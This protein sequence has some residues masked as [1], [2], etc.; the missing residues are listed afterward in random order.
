M[1]KLIIGIDHNPQIFDNL[2]LLPP[3][4]NLVIN[5]IP[6]EVYI[7]HR[8]ETSF[9]T[10]GIISN[11][12][13]LITSNI[14]SNHPNIF[15]IV[16]HNKLEQ[17]LIINRAYEHYKWKNFIPLGFHYS[18]GSK[19]KKYHNGICDN[20][21]SS[22]SKYA[23]FKKFLSSNGDNQA[24][25]PIHLLSKFN[26]SIK[27]MTNKELKKDYA[28]S[29]IF[30]DLDYGDD[31]H[32]IYNN[33][34]YFY[35]NFIP[36]NLIRKEYRILFFGNNIKEYTRK[37]DKVF[38]NESGKEYYQGN[39]DFTDHNEIKL[40]NLGTV[41]SIPHT[42]PILDIIKYSGMTFG[43]MDIVELI[44]NKIVILEF[45]SQ[46][47]I[48]NIDPNHIY[49]LT[50]EWFSNKVIDHFKSNSEFKNSN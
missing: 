19:F 40:S 46:F 41:I 7:H 24:V 43:S 4:L 28:E 33:E 15:H 50:V 21:Y 6:T 38:S 31:E 26:H 25:I 12:D 35:Q 42:K 30:T 18:E 16:S 23:V 17:Q 32:F 13:L 37:R 27:N 20:Y 2:Y 45:Q 8:P 11:C 1:K 14:K 36:S 49:D 9:N 39:L 47:G 10:S 22:F 44:D 5:D 29:V 34:D 48:S 3:K